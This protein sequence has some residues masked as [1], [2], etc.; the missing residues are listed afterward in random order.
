M[1]LNCAFLFSDDVHLAKPELVLDAKTATKCF[2][3][4]QSSSRGQYGNHLIIHE[5][6]V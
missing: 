6:N 3:D 5:D 4:F 1:K 2:I